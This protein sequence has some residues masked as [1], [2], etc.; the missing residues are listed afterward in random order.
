MYPRIN[1]RQ[2]FDLRADPHEMKDLADAAEHQ[3]TVTRTLAMLRESQAR[4]GDRQTLTT[5]KPLPPEFDFSKVQR[6][7]LPAKR[8]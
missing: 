5:D 3:E 1:K 2:L 4:Y 6:K 7:A 8:D